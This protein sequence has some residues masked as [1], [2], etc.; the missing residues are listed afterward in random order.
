MREKTNVTKKKKK[1]T[2]F[3]LFVFMRRTAEE[4]DVGFYVK[5]KEVF[6]FKT[7]CLPCESFCSVA[8]I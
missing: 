6:S 1:Y 3:T 5:Q 8:P 4:I 7:S 2:T